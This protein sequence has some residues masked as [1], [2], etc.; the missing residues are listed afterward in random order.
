MRKI[1]VFQLSVLMLV[2]CGGSDEA[3]DQTNESVNENSTEEL[4]ESDKIQFETADDYTNKA[5]TLIGDLYNGFGPLYDLD[6][7][8]A[9]EDEFMTEITSLEKKISETEN[10]INR[11]EPYGKNTGAYEASINAC[12]KAIKDYCSFFKENTALMSR[13]D[14][15]WSEEE[16]NS[17]VDKDDQLKAVLENAM[18][19]LY[20]ESNNYLNAQP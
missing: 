15:E 5:E 8:D 11:M 10:E 2:S 4:A 12:I 1:A 20:E 13:P 7:M 3:E 19:K 18:D 6:N 9:P 16:M 14:Y 17:F